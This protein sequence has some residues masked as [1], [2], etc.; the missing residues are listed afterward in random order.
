M[1]HFINEYPY[2]RSLSFERG[3]AHL[4]TSDGSYVLSTSAFQ[5]L[6]NTVLE[7]LWFYQERYHEA[8]QDAKEWCH[9]YQIVSDLLYG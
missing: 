8:E 1:K 5:E 7:E 9:D 3:D 2:L 6:Y 4:S